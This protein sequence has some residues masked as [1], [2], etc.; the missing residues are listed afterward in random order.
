MSSENSMINFRKMQQRLQNQS[1]ATLCKSIAISGLFLFL[2]YTFFFNHL[3]YNHSSDDFLSH[4]KVVTM[5]NLSP[6]KIIDNSRTNI[7]HIV[8]GIAGT[9][10][11]WKFR[12]SYIE[13]WWRPNVTRGYLFLDRPPTQE[14]LPW[15][16]SSPP[17]QVNENITGLKAFQN[18][19]KKFQIRLFRTILETFRLVGDRDVRWFVMGDDDTVLF[20]DN[21]IEVL[22]K[23]DHTQHLYIGTNSECV[24][25]NV[26]ASFGMAFGGAG[27][28]LS[29]P[30]AEALVAKLDVC[31]QRYH[32]LYA[33]D[34]MLYSCLA[35][36]GVAALTREQGFHQIDLHHDISGLLS[37]HPQVPVISLHHMDVVNPIFPSMNRYKSINHLMKAAEVDSSRLLQQSVCYN[38]QS[39]WSISVSWGYSAHVYENIYS[40][41]FLIK[42][43]ET[44]RPWRRSDRPPLYMFN[45][46]PLTRNSC[47]VPHVFFFDSMENLRGNQV[48]LTYIRSSPRN[49]PPCPATG[50]H[51]ADVIDKIQVFSPATERKRVGIMECCDIEHIAYMNV[52]DVKL[53]ACTEDDSI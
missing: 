44:F 3:N 23:Y 14:F 53:R 40:R 28:A 12:K 18:I 30:L 15:P 35:D 4:F 5:N 9:V 41:N 25:S 27:Y 50:N 43:L 20:V 47:E 6:P 49:L 29:Y 10:N 19:Q 21:L 2:F 42:P 32:D 39:N 31:I 7:S 13:S 37:A 33:S 38:R 51:S 46:R 16:A 8:F 17:F 1:L 45:T 36:L 26:Y 48:V 22:A 34:L 24:S 11:G 52:T